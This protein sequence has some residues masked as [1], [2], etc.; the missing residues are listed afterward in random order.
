MSVSAL[1]SSVSDGAPPV[2]SSPALNDAVF[3][4]SG[5]VLPSSSCRSGLGSDGSHPGAFESFLQGSS[6]HP[7]AFE[8]FLQGSSEHPG[9]FESFLQGSGPL[10]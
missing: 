1:S 3:P 9:A 8:S 6:E 5:G 2:P 10:S 7:G 4:V